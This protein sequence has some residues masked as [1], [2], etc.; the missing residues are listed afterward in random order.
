MTHSLLLF[1]RTYVS[2]LFL[3]LLT[4]GLSPFFTRGRKVKRGKKEEGREEEEEEGEEEEEEEQ[5][6]QKR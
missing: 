4:P 6:T 3:P 1:T 2:G 5:T